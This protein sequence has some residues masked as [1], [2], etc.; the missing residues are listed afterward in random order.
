MG[1]GKGKETFTFP[2]RREEHC[3][4]PRPVDSISGGNHPRGTVFSSLRAALSCLLPL[5]PLLRP[6]LPSLPPLPPPLSLSL[7]LWWFFTSRTRHVHADGRG[8]NGGRDEHTHWASAARD[9]PNLSERDSQTD[10]ST[11][12][13][14]ILASRRWNSRRGGDRYREVVDARTLTRARRRAARLKTKG[15]ERGWKRGRA[16]RNGGH[17]GKREKERR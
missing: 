10:G 4:A 2:E 8:R 11:L 14:A 15:R 7:S 6:L 13:R 9:S 3:R 1:K 5:S 12:A 16:T 17:A